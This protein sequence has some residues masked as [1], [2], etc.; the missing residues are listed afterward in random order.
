MAGQY[1]S[2]VTGAENVVETLLT[3]PEPASIPGMNLRPDG[4]RCSLAAAWSRAYEE[5]AYCRN[6]SCR[7]CRTPNLWD[8]WIICDVH[9][10][11]CFAASPHAPGLLREPDLP[12]VALNRCAL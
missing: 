1:A 5:F 11:R 4:D 8:C 3:I 7:N 2:K 6:V 10:L 9:L 12:E